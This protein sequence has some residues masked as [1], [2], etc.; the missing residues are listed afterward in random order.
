VT[1]VASPRAARLAVPRWLDGRLVLGVL[2]VA[3]SVAAGA[4]VLTAADNLTAVYVAAHDLAPGEH[5]VAG[6]L[7]VG[8]VRLR[9]EAGLYIAAAS[10]P[11]VGYVVTRYVAAHELVPVAAL[12]TASAAQRSRFV[13]VP[14]QPG[15]LA[16]A[17]ARG[18][19]VDVYLTPKAGAGEPVPQPVLV[20]AGVPVESR[21][22]G[23]RTFS[24]SSAFSVVLAV[25]VDKVAAVVHA[26]E[27]GTIDLV[28]VPHTDSGEA[29]QPATDSS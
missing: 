23:T 26:V 5:V 12:A 14:V 28:T 21:T 27:G 17:L 15:H 2:L 4:R 18:D 1:D 29:P 16:D 13:T 6:D 11:P 19:L 10:A 7:A 8:H 22:G 3:L 9:G 24:A 25:P 20:L